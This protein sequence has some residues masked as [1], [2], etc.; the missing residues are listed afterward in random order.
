MEEI[1]FST[2]M[3]RAALRGYLSSSTFSGAFPRN[4]S[5][6]LP[7]EVRRHRSTFLRGTHLMEVRLESGGASRHAQ[8]V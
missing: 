3:V 7:C 8:G 4:K 2:G 1:K 5:Y 6:V